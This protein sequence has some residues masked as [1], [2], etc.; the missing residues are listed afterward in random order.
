VQADVI[1]GGEFSGICRWGFVVVRSHLPPALAAV[2]VLV[3]NFETGPLQH[4]PNPTDTVIAIIR[5][6]LQSIANQKAFGWT[7]MNIQTEDFVRCAAFVSGSLLPQRMGPIFL[8]S[9]DAFCAYQLT[10]MPL[11]IFMN[12]LVPIF[13]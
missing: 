11:G 10:G 1:F 8:H 13:T 2:I 7:I 4:R 3:V 5:V 12:G 9:L 6:L